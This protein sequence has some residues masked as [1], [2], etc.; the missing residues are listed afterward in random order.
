M[1]VKK[2]ISEILRE[3]TPERENLLEILHRIQDEEPL[4]YIPVESIQ[5]I[6]DYVKM[7][8]SE[9]YGVISFYSLLST[10]P[11]SPYI[12]RVCTSVPCDIMGS[13]T[14]L[15]V[16]ETL[17]GIS[18]GHTTDD[19]LFTLETASCLGLCD[20]APAMMINDDTYGPLTTAEIEQ[21]IERKKHERNPDCP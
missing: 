6:A 3:Y 13:A 12:I 14:V 19:G 20:R 18:A 21:I 8:P 17:L 11:R 10:T 16:L 9:V 5:F 4:Q 2:R 15:E 1:N 7:S